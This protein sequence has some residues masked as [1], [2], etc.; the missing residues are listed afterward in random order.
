MYLRADIVAVGVILSPVLL[1]LTY[2]SRKVKAAA[3]PVE[4]KNIEEENTESEMPE[5]V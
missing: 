4:E 1:L 2:A 5:L 3:L